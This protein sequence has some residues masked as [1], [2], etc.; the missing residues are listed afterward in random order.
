M[1]SAVGIYLFY[2]K[3]GTLGLKG[4][5]HLFEKKLLT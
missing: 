5:V 4:Q 1:T 3:K 2:G